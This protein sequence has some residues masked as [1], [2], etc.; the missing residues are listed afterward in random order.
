MML[1]RF[2]FA[3]PLFGLARIT[4][5]KWSSSFQAALSVGLL[6]T[7]PM[8]CVNSDLQEP[9]AGLGMRLINGTHTACDS[10]PADVLVGNTGD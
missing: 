4:G 8:I 9:H 3:P 2:L 1:L 10:S 6:T 7:L 5:A